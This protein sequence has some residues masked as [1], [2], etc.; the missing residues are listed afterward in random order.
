MSVSPSA[1]VIDTHGEL[2]QFW[3]EDVLFFANLLA[4]FFGNERETT[5]LEETVGEVD[6]YG[7]R[8]IPILNLLFQ[9][10]HNTLVLERETASALCLYFERELGLSLPELRIMPPGDYRKIG[11]LLDDG[12]NGALGDWL[13]L[14][15]DQPAS[16]IDGY[17]TDHT[18]I[19][20]ADQLQKKTVATFE[21]CRRGNNK[22]L[23]HQ[24]VEAIGLPVI[25]TR[26]VGSK[27]EVEQ[28][29]S[30]LRESGFEDAVLKSQIG[31]SGI[32]IQRI[33]NIADFRENRL[34]EIQNH[35]FFEGPVI[36]QGWIKP[37]QGGVSQINSPSV[38]MFVDEEV[39]WLFDITDQILSTES[40]HEGNVSPPPYLKE[41]NGLRDELL[42][43]AGLVGQW[44]YRQGYRGTASTDFLWVKRE[45]TAAVEVYVC[46]IN[47]RVTGATYPSV[48]ARH[49]TPNGAWL[50]RNLRLMESIDEM[51]LLAMLRDSRL[52][53]LPG[54]TS[55]I[56]PINFNFGHD[57][58]VLKG[59]FLC[60]APTTVECERLLEQAE[61]SL[62]VE[63]HSDR[64]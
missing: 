33:C 55:G 36:A 54:R 10:G 58:K 57:G 59:Q 22:L 48:L 24:Y 45:E 38:Q 5:E 62:P 49:F 50:M 43:Q 64:D 9:G 44:L 20:I 52:L 13:G 1:R 3:Q 21:G 34:A 41:T 18:L 29:M 4:L 26:I 46:E 8:L 51:E 63:W 11:N 60:L 35:L 61:S 25:E 53:F 27:Q 14:F 37:G 42:R 47:A 16:R 6:S 2:P 15:L 19:G 7:G 28:A 17:V 32:G 31:A 39:I 23:L 12:D 56:L 30:E 40:V